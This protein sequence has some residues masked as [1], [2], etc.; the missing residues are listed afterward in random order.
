MI[1]F[2]ISVVPPK[3]GWT[4]LPPELIIVAESGGLVFPPFKAG[5]GLHLISASRGGTA[6]SGRRSRAMGSSRR[7]ATLRSAAWRRR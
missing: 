7:V 6:R 3:I 5:S 4:R 1:S 2:M